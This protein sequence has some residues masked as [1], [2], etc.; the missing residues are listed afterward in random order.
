VHDRL[1][2]SAVSSWRWTLA[3]DLAFWEGAGI[4]HV[5]LSYRKL[6]EAGLDSAVAAVASA[7][8]RVD[9]LGELGWWRLDDAATWAPQQTRVA[10]A[11]ETAAELG[12]P[13]VVLTTGPAGGL[14]WDQAA[15]AL[16]EALGPISRLAAARG[17]RLAVENTSPMRLDLSFVT[18][19][20]DTVDL[21]CRAG[22]AVCVEVN[23]CFAERH[24]ARTI[25]AAAPL[26]GHVQVSD[27]VIGSTTSPD[28]AVPGD[29]DIPLAPIVATLLA[30]GYDGSFELEMVGPRIE[31]EGYASAIRRGVER[32]GEILERAGL[33]R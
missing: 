13:C 25:E 9:C 29:G 12:A 33:T 14:S 18:T 26:I 1:S 19:L 21:A 11:V 3:E 20:R 15:L 4:D 16:T 5:G 7:G 10:L 23:S 32:F 31:A 27:F 2:V 8:V 6:E 17:V 28:R 30:A 22:T 24:L